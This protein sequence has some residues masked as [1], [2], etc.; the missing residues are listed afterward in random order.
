MSGDMAG[1]IIIWD[2]V[3]R[4][5]RLLKEHT[6][7]VTSIACINSVIVSAGQDQTIRIFDGLA[8]GQITASVQ[9]KQHQKRKNKN[10]NSAPM[11]GFGGKSNALGAAALDGA[12]GRYKHVYDMH[13]TCIYMP[14]MKSTSTV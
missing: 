13:M 12:L 3:G 10:N 9:S 4:M 7:I 5:V 1:K 14:Y 8:V 6:D 11:H 2:R